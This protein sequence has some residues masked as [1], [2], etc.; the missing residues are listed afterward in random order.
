ML[1]QLVGYRYEILTPSAPQNILRT[2]GTAVVAGD[3]G[4][5]GVNHGT[6]SSQVFTAPVATAATGINCTGVADLNWNRV[7]G[8]YS[9]SPR[10]IK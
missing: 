2:G 3:A 8:C 7:I 6:L 5:G 10:L 4:G 9:L 1:L